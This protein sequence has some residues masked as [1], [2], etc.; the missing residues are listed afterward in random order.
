MSTG[1]FNGKQFNTSMWNAQTSTTT[2]LNVDFDAT[3][4]D[5]DIKFNNFVFG[6]NST[7]DA[8]LNNVQYDSMPSRDFRTNPV[9]RD[10]GEIINGNF[11]R[12]KKIEIEAT[13]YGDSKTDLNEKIDNMK[14]ILAQ[15]N[16]T[17]DFYINGGLRRHIANAV[18]TDRIIDRRSYNITFQPFRIVFHSVEPFC[19]DLNYTSTTNRDA[20]SLEFNQEV[21]NQGTTHTKPI[22]IFNFSAASSATA[23]NIKN[24]VTNE[25]IEISET[26][27]AGDIIKFD[28]ENYEVTQNGTA[29]DYDGTF[30]NLETGIN[31][32]TF[33]TTATSAT[34]ALTTKFKQQYL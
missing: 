7:A 34:L 14:K 17:L 22:F 26:I 1:Q 13:L 18:N 12:N 31:S 9:P 15:K 24:T 16:G 25:E 28:S 32:I 8:I 23:I 27:S 6:V 19:K 30:I 29:I 20:T 11:F 33:T 5:G 10:D 21:N 3:D 2:T 4:F